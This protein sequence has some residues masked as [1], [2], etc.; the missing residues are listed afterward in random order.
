[1]Y[2]TTLRPLIANASF[3]PGDILPAADECR[4]WFRNSASLE[5]FVFSSIFDELI[6]RDWHR[7]AVPTSE[8]NR[9][10]TDVLPRM[11]DVLDTLPAD[12]TSKLRALIIGYHSSI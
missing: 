8:W 2:P 12:P 9:F 5:A 3:A 6:A 1:M 11:I 7:Q 4:D 10:L